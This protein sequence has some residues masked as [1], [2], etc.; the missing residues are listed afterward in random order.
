MK[1]G[2]RFKIGMRRFPNIGATLDADGS[3]ELVES[4]KQAMEELGA[5][6]FAGRLFAERQKDVETWIGKTELQVDR[7]NTVLRG[8]TKSMRLVKEGQ[9]RAKV[10][11]RTLCSWIY[12]VS[13][14]RRRW[15]CRPQML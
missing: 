5:G 13:L 14:W 7:L 6:G 9:V 2:G 15:L 3:S 1:A 10:V 8:L 11:V 4:L 12:V